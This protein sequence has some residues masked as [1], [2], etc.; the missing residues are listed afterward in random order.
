MAE[1]TRDREKRAELIEHMLTT[2]EDDLNER[3]RPN[4]FIED[5]RDQF[6]KTGWL[7]DKQ[8]AA[9]RNFYERC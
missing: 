4:Q 3:G 5:I 8:I 9:L 1:L 7:T 6:D 2:V